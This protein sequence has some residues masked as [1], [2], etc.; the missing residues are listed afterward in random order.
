MLCV[1][2]AS[3]LELPRSDESKQADTKTTPGRLLRV[4]WHRAR[5]FQ[6]RRLILVMLMLSYCL[7][8]VTAMHY[9]R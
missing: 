7:S 9:W 5:L 3:M 8:G 2:C 4:A 6:L 1:A